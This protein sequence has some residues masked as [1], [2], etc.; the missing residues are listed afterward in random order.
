MSG[1]VSE[2]IWFL[3]FQNSILRRQLDAFRCGNKF[4]TLRE[5]YEA[6]CRKKDSRIRELEHELSD[7]R[8]RVI[9]VRSK[10]SEIVD[11]AYAECH[12]EILKERKKTN[13]ME[14][15]ALRAESQRD[16]AL[17]KAKEWREKYYALSSKLEE[18]EGMVKKLT[19]QVNKDFENSGIPS[20]KQG[21][22]RKKIVNSREKTGKSRGGQPGHEGHR[23]TQKK[24]TSSDMIKDPQEFLTNPDYYKTG[25]LIRRQKIVLKLAIE[26]IEYKASEFRRRSNGSRIHA[27]FPAGFDTDISY[28]DSVKA[29]A[30]LL[31]N[32]CSVSDNKICSLL[33][34]V[35]GGQLA[36][37]VGTVNK[38]VKEFAQKSRPEREGIVRDLM[39]SPVINVDFTN[40]N[41]NGQTKQ[42][43]IAAS[44]SKDAY[45]L[46]GRDNK[47]HK[48]IQGTPVENYVGTMVH[49]HDTTFYKYGQKHQECMQHNERYLKG[50]IENENE[51][52]W[53]TRMHELIR[54]MIHYRNSLGDEDFDT[55]EV[56]RLET[57][58]DEILELAQNEY[59]YDPPSDYYKEG[60]NLYKRL[61]EYKE[62]ELLFLHD[63]NVPPSNNLAERLA[64]VYKRK[65]HQ[66]IVNRGEE[67]YRYR[68]EGLS[69]ITTYKRRDEEN[70]YEKVK[71]IFA[72]QTDMSQNARLK[73]KSVSPT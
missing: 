62:S 64:R 45:M 25:N 43:L 8:K 10:W 73:A 16:D 30:Y 3:K 28:D 12:R 14:E 52:E 31:S 36:I 7:T 17:D 23:L 58:Y 5:D 37:S 54:K 63:K 56:L 65:Q 49:D 44:P 21:G 68:C 20:S 51:L 71:E 60:Y 61:V 18:S 40:A 42:V 26:I 48:G 11:D 72:R 13:A 47:G 4:Q 24:A 67:N 22:K 59:E 69:V 39:E 27:P 6:V 38:L 33:K 9:D 66:M 57:E 53:N 70:L 1:P 46:F 19:A 2:Y 55:A 41:V 15:R 32:E 34:E 50:S 29:L 35:T